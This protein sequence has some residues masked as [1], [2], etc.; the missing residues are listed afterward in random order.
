MEKNH[1]KTNDFYGEYKLWGTDDHRKIF[2]KNW[3]SPQTAFTAY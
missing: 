1:R 3:Q 2:K